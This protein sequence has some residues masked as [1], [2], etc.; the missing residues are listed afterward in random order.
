MIRRFRAQDAEALAAYRSDPEVARYQA[1]EPPCSTRAAEAFI[2]SL[3]PLTPGTPGQWFQFAVGLAPGGELI[4]DVALCPGERDPRQAELG[5]SFSRAHQ[6]RGLATEAV[7]C[8]VAYA[9]GAFE[10]H[11]VV[12][13]TDLRNLR[14]QR[15]LERAGFRREGK[16]HE[17]SWCKGAWA[18]ELLY[19]RLRS[20]DSG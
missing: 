20:E 12:A 3:E 11:R 16:L 19:A 15:L 7:R 13:A 1:W 18:S 6:G 10:L 17:I 14:A 4:G 5:F 8:V 2:A 9:F